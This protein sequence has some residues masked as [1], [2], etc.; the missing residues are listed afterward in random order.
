MA[1]DIRVQYKFKIPFELKEKL[2][3]AASKN[4]RSL[5]GEVIARLE[6]TFSIHKRLGDLEDVAEEAEETSND[7]YRRVDT[8]E[9]Q[10]R[11]LLNPDYD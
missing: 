5:S 10:M 3:A 7:L 8:L 6:Q 9:S 1:T 4:N 2:E 11:E